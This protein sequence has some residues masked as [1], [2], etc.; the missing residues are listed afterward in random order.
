MTLIV[1]IPG[2]MDSKYL[3]LLSDIKS[4]VFENERLIL[5]FKKASG[6]MF[7]TNVGRAEQKL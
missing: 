2:S 4:I 7:F 3:S 6:R 1:Y 5:Y